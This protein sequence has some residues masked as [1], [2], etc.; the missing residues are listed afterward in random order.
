[1]KE[2]S[3][4]GSQVRTITSSIVKGQEYELQILLPGNYNQNT[5]KY[6]VV[7]LMDSQ[8]DFP[9]VKSLYG[10]QYYDGF[11]PELIIVGVTWGGHKPN[12]DSLR[13]RDYTPTPET[14]LPQS[15]G[16]DNF[17]SFMRTE[18]FPFIE[19]NY[20]AEN[21]DRTIAGCSLGG[22]ITLYALF[23]QPDM[24]DNYVAASPAF[25]WGREVIYKFEQ[26]FSDTKSGKRLYMTMG[27]VERNVADYKR[28]EQYLFSKKYTNL[29]LESRILDNTG[30][31][32]TKAEGFSRG[33][34]Y[35]FQKNEVALS[36]AQLNKYA[37]KYSLPNKSTVELKVEKDKLV[38]YFSPGN[39]FELL[40][41]N[42]HDFYSLSEFLNI[43]FTDVGFELNRY[44]N[45]QSL[46]KIK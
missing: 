4:P 35:A 29:K 7:Y 1:V 31:S 40:A 42:E 11:I 16:A 25:G 14:R 36:P 18:L 46:T 5:K 33:L 41:E 23:S 6:P 10:Q 26:N 22:L 43:H 37:G 12:P 8:W 17:L 27:G 9:L 15:G 24:F 21:T 3:I 44:N 32:G 38:L 13:A 2:V 34:Q 19:A 45:T 39:R 30:H 28:F 20:R